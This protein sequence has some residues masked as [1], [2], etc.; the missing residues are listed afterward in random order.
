MYHEPT[1]KCLK[2][3]YCRFVNDSQYGDSVEALA[4]WLRWMSPLL[5]EIDMHGAYL[6]GPGLAKLIPVLQRLPNLMKVDLS[7]S[8]VE[9]VE[10]LIALVQSVK[11]IQHLFAPSMSAED[12]DRLIKA[13]G[14]VG[15]VF[16]SVEDE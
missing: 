9:D 16:P 3:D 5:E 15:I 8:K 12:K 1:L 11:T 14:G 2:L 10:Q 4:R 13:A 7:D 6:D